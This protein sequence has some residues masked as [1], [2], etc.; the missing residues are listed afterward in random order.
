MKRRQRI[1]FS[2]FGTRK[3]TDLEGAII[4]TFFPECKDMTIKE[5]R[6]RTD[7]S[8]ERVNS[9]LKSLTEKKI[10]KE[11]S[12]GKT[13]I[14]SL[15][16]GDLF[17]EWGFDSYMLER[18]IEFMKKYRII[19]EGIKEIMHNPL[20]WM[21]I[22]FGSYSKGTESKQSDVDIL[23]VSNKKGE[24]ENFIRSLK[25]KYGINFTPVVLSELEFPNMKKDNPTTMT[26]TTTRY[27]INWNPNQSC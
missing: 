1:T 17:A 26:I 4:Y 11:E 2:S 7:Y 3:L 12:K 18:E 13:L 6:E 14:Y 25:H 10:V 15:N 27:S 19:Y 24:T 5:I 8:Y 23:C 16:L 21:I 9:A 20:I 22:L